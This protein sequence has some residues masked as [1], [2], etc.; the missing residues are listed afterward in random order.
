[1]EK[2]RTFILNALK[3]LGYEIGPSANLETYTYHTLYPD[4]NYI[5]ENET[6]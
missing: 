6:P 5:A 3:E 1:M 4:H 2:P